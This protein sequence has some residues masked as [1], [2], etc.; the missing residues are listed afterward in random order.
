MFDE[1]KQRLGI[2]DAVKTYDKQIQS[3]IEY[4][5]YDMEESGVSKDTL[6]S[7]SAPV[8]NCVAMF[9]EWHMEPDP[10]IAE[11]YHKMYDGAIF[12]LSINDAANTMGG[13]EI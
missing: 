9:C 11:A 7:E 13:V 6:D 12:R 3:L 8:I 5:L 1:I 2:H 4:A 10:T